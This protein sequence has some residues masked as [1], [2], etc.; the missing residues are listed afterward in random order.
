[1]LVYVYLLRV[2]LGLLGSC[3]S[4]CVHTLLFPDGF[5]P[6]SVPLG[7]NKNKN[8]QIMFAKKKKK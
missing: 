3:E 5:A 6:L 7:L 4:L 2:I 1:M 8:L